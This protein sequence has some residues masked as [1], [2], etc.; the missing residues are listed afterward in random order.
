MSD[1][2]AE[3]GMVFACICDVFGLHLGSR[4]AAPHGEP[5]ISYVYIHNMIQPNTLEGIDNGE[6][7]EDEFADAEAT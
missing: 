3:G 1:G 5:S 6:E 7:E 4:Y 2:S